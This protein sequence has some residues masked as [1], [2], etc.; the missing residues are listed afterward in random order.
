MLAEV[1]P[2]VEDELR[3]RLRRHEDD[4]PQADAPEP[5]HEGHAHEHGAPEG[6][7]VAPERA[8]DREPGVPQERL[9]QAPGPGEQAEREAGH[10]V[11]P[12]IAAEPMLQVLRVRNLAVIDELEVEFGPGLNVVTGETGAGKSILVAALQLV[13]GARGRPDLVRTGAD[14]GEVEALFALEPQ[15][16]HRLVAAGLEEGEELVV[17]RVIEAGGRTRAYANGRLLPLAQL[18]ELVRGL[19]DISSQHEHQTLANPATHL[20]WLDAFAGLEARCAEVRAAY[21]RAEAAARRVVESRE[22]LRRL[23]ER[24]D[25]LRFQVAEIGRVAP[26]EG[27]EEELGAEIAGLRHADQLHGLLVRAEAGLY[28]GDRAV[29]AILARVEADLGAAARVDARLA[30]LVEPVADAR[31]ALED[32]GR[33]IG[34]AARAAHADPA[35]LAA[36]EERQH[37]LRRLAR[38]FGT[39]ADA[40]AHARAA[41]EELAT[42]VGADDRLTREEAEAVAGRAVAVDLARALSAARRR[43]ADR[44]GDAITGELAS[45]GMGEAKVEVSVAPLEGAAGVVV[46]GARLSATGFDRVEF[47]IATNLGEEPRPLR[48]VASGGELSR[49]LLALKRV[50]AGL[51]PAGTYV[52]DEVDTGVG[53]AVAEVI[54]RKVAEV[55]RHHQVICI[56]H[57][58]QV[59]AFGERHLHVRKAVADGRTRSTISALGEDERR[60]E[61]ARMLGGVTVGPAAREAAAELLRQAGA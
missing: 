4:R 56:T 30:R 9:G 13:L 27:E 59:A 11:S 38:K 60:E 3:R 7:G 58:P 33:E 1:P 43:E 55:A 24:E 17:R 54:G 31:A 22:Q 20:G 8:R 29:T 46:D 21:D 19:V 26:V 14:R 49:A 61:I 10:G 15:A 42:I 48:R 36:L 41:E 44:L 25:F 6:P 12:N 28:S 40:L 51:G 32:A 5:A 18:E 23:G 39:L 34:R 16:R 2:L 53:G 50:L 47:L 52:F 57:L 35:R 45:L 37:E